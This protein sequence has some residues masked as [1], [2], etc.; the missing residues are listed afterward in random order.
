[1]RRIISFWS[2]ILIVLIYAGTAA[3][4]KTSLWEQ[5]Q[6]EEFEAGTPKNL[7]L[8]SR[9]DVMLA[10]KIE[11]FT[12]LKENQVWALVED[13]A[14]NLYAATGNE[15]KIYKI[16]AGTLP[17]FVEKGVRGEQRDLPIRCILGNGNRSRLH[18]RCFKIGTQHHLH[19]DCFAGTVAEFVKAEALNHRCPPF[20]LYFQIEGDVLYLYLCIRIADKL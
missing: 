6:Q 11:G 12:K 2:L 16:S 18:N 14:G 4:V 13:S 5:Q 8:T 3:A 10:P 19:L 9:G 20:V 15:G 1:M 17:E 7:S